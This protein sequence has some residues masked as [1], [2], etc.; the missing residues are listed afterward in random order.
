Y[1][2]DTIFLDASDHNLGFGKIPLECYNGH[3]RIISEQQ[4]GPIYLYP[5]DIKE[6]E[7]TSVLLVNDEKG[8]GESGTL[9]STLGYY[10]SSDARSS[11]KER[12]GQDKYLKTLKKNYGPDVDISNLHI[13]SLTQLEEPLKINYDI[14][15]KNGFDGDIIYFN[16]VVQGAY[17]ENPFQATTRKF[18]VELPYP[19]NETYDLTMDIPDKYKVDELPKSVQ[20]DFN[21]TDGIFLYSI[22]KDNYTVQLHM[23]LKI[24][25][26]FFLPEDYSSLRDFFTMVVK[27]QSEQVVFK[28]K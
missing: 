2:R 12:D 21:G 6:S 25:K 13:D 11:L 17:K 27:K 20:A 7:I 15:Y 28:K 22:L 19:I 26:A 10:K 9:E 14:S 8:I 5:S 24:N 23:Q 4:S 3:S 1:G 18:P 16:P